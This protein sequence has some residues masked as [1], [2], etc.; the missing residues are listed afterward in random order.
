VPPRRPVCIYSYTRTHIYVYEYIYI[1]IR[2]CHPTLSHLA[3]NMVN[4]VELCRRADQAQVFAM[5]A[6]LITTSDGKK[7]GKSEGGMFSPPLSPTFP[8]FSPLS[9]LSLSVSSL[10]PLSPS[11]CLSFLSFFRSLSLSF[12]PPTPLS[13]YPPCP[14]ISI[15]PPLSRWLAWLCSEDDA[16]RQVG[17]SSLASS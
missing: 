7:M 11:L 12:S 13:F 16:D 15:S 17:A 3:G 5:T 14:P 8:H 9:P 10:L 2:P 6:P 4:G 1:Y